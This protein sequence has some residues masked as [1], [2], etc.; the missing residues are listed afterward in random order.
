MPG[1]GAF[2]RSTNGLA[3]G[4][5]LA[6]AVLHG[7]YEIVERDAI[8]LWDLRS[9]SQQ[10]ETRIDLATVADLVNRA[11]LDRYE[12]AD[13]S[14]MVWDVSSDTRIPAF[15][16]VIV[17]RHAHARYLPLP[18]AFGSGCHL[19]PAM[20][21]T[22]SLT[23]AAQSRLT[24]IAGARDDLSRERYR[25]FQSEEALASQRKRSEEPGVVDMRRH[26]SS[27]GATLEEDLHM[28]RDRLDDAGFESILFVDLSRASLPV[29]VVRVII[30]GMEGATES[31][32]YRPGVRARRLFG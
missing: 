31:P 13:F 5:N 27:A 6:E 8:A 11:L 20:A 24:C 26:R 15:R 30:P 18:A 9:K 28:L 2:V 22:R 1:S 19:D 16:C 10:A 21:L 14:V 4:N 17:D 32:D 29:S 7:I 12:A 3:S 23:E 25:L